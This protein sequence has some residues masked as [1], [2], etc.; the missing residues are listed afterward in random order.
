M[1]S[2]YEY[3]GPFK[4]M[5]ATRI[6][7]DIVFHLNIDVGELQIVKLLTR[8]VLGLALNQNYL[9]IGEKP[10]YLVYA[11]RSS[12]CSKLILVSSIKPNSQYICASRI[13]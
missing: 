1:C 2:E 10:N 3:L 4:C 7:K 9:A 11:I 12:Q 5:K 13:S 6:H 8:L